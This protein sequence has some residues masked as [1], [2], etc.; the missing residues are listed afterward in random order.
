VREP[1]ATSPDRASW[2][3]SQ[4]RD[5]V[6]CLRSPRRPRRLARHRPA[7]QVAAPRTRTPSPRRHRRQTPDVRTR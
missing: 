2:P 3:G 7:G 4:R 5:G 6:R 1:P